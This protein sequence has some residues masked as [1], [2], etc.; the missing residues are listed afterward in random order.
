METMLLYGPSSHNAMNLFVVFIM[1]CCAKTENKK[2]MK[3]SGNHQI[4]GNDSL[5]R[6][7]AKLPTLDVLLGAFL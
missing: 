3:R 4:S 1:L 2:A 6:W 5:K 7:C